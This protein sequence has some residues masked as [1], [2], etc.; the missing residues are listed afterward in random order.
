MV[1]SFSSTTIKQDAQEAGD[2]VRTFLAELY[3]HGPNGPSW[4]EA[5][6]K[7][8]PHVMVSDCRSLVAHLNFEAPS[9][10]QEA[11][12]GRARSHAPINL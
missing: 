2:R 4:H 12:A 5:S 7:E 10:L 11:A 3:G 9:R 1:V 6:R 8:I